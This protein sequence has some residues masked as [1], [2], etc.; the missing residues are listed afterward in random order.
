MKAT[1]QNNLNDHLDAFNKMSNLIELIEKTAK[2]I[3]DAF[4]D[5]H[6]VI[7]FGNGGSAADA[8]HFA[9]ELTGRYLKERQGLPA[10]ALST[11]TSSVTAIGNDYGYEQVF[12]RQLEAL[13]NDGD[14]VIGISTSGNSQNVIEALHTASKLN[15]KTV[16]ITGG[17]GGKMNPCCDINLIAPSDHTPRI[18]EM[19]ILI[20]HTLCNLIEDAFE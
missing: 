7:I 5:G 3:I 6:K 9:A 11:N 2:L 1:I 4:K 17:K 15:C 13:A 14:I 18:Q 20:I 12:S 19:H 8:Q 10:L 16:G